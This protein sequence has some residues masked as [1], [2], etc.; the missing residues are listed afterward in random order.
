MSRR[1]HHLFS[2]H[3][4][5]FPQLHFVGEVDVRQRYLS[6]ANADVTRVRIK[7]VQ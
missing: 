6:S 5:L 3:A 4:Q 2:T 1:S 7:I